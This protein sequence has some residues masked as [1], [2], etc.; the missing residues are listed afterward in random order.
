M[1]QPDKNRV[2]SS[3][4]PRG[5]SRPNRVV[6]HAGIVQPA[7][8]ETQSVITAEQ[9][10]RVLQLGELLRSVLTP[11]ELDRLHQAL[12]TSRTKQNRDCEGDLLIP[13]ALDVDG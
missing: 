6:G 1:S 13:I 7:Q 10:T 5:S 8:A 9:V 3:K 2:T 11:A 4:T 12:T